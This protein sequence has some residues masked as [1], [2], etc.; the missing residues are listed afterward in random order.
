M[1]NLKP[2]DQIWIIGFEVEDEFYMVSRQTV[3]GFL[4]DENKVEC[5]DDFNTFHV[6]FDDIYPS[7]AEAINAMI[8]RLT[9]LRDELV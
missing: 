6:A 7:K 8:S 2:G 1:K 5:E 9:R 4:E 3:I